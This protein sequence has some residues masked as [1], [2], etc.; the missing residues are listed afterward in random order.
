MHTSDPFDTLSGSLDEFRSPVMHTTQPT[1]SFNV[2]R[3]DATELGVLAPTLADL[4]KDSV[5]RGASLGF[6]APLAQPA[7]HEYWLSLHDELAAGS[8]VLLG[9]W[10]DTRPIGAAQL[11]FPAWQNARHRAEVQKVF[12]ASA[13]RG[14][15]I[16]RALMQAL[17]AAAHQSGRSLLILGTRRA[18]PAERFYKRLG[19]REVG[20]IPGYTL[21]SSGER[22][23]NLML[24]SE[25]S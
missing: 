25:L 5:D 17:H 15:G 9:A 19:Y 14:L 20:V 4:L 10:M 11:A 23:D 18:E 13:A 24:Y 1:L 2:R 8:R 16:G 21:G 7:G 12:V 22:H 3:I 6:L